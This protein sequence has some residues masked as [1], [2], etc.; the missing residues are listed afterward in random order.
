MKFFK[1]K[2]NLVQIAI[3]GVLFLASFILVPNFA[4]AATTFL[5]ADFESV[6]VGDTAII[7]VRMDTDGKNPNVV[8]GNISIKAGADKIKITDLS[9]AGSA[10]TFWPQYPSLGPNSTI[11]FTGGT[12]GG[13][14]QK[15]GLLLKIIFVAEKEGEVI[16]EP[17]NIKA[18]NNDGKATPIEVFNN[19][20]TIG[21]VSV[22]DSLPKNQWEEII[23]QDKE[24]PQDLAATFG[25]DDSI[26]DGK[27]FITI[28]ASD[29]QSGIDYY[30]VIEGNNPAVR[31]GETYVLLDQ[32]EASI[33]I[34][35]VY[36]KAGNQSKISLAPGSQPKINY[37]RLIIVFIVLLALVYGLFKIM[38]LFKRKNVWHK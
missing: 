30:E 10:L 13:F 31:S 11:Y 14:K 25:R 5:T 33:I 15:S 34:V 7:N 3:S 12:P 26:F 16:F 19:P 2:F 36:D 22:K 8:E 4:L 1:L 23:S 27:K 18:Y 28:S 35:A 17:N 38:E 37:A 21:I 6:A 29:S 20:L 9:V 24:P 32:S